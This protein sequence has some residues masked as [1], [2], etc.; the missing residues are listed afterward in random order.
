MTSYRIH[1]DGLLTLARLASQAPGADPDAILEIVQSAE[2]EDL[3]A[4][5]EMPDVGDGP[6]VGGV[7]GVIPVDADTKPAKPE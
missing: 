3:P 6:G 1:G 7:L 5:P 4:E 2:R